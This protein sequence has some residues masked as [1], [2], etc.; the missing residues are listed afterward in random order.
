MNCTDIAVLALRLLAVHLAVSVLITLTQWLPMLRGLEVGSEVSQVENQWWSKSLRITIGLQS[1]LAVVVYASA[2]RLGAWLTNG[3]R[4]ALITD[5]LALGAVAISSAGILILSHLLDFIPE[6]AFPDPRP[7]GEI[8]F[9]EVLMRW[10]APVLLALMGGWALAQ[11]KSIARSLFRTVDSPDSPAS[12]FAQAIL[13]SLL[14]LWFVVG[15]LPSIVQRAVFVARS[16]NPESI[17]FRIQHG[18]WCA[19]ELDRRHLA[20]RLRPRAHCRR[21]RTG[22]HLA[23]R[24]HG[25]PDGGALTR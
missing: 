2:G 25:R 18:L 14:G 23:P 11:P 6:A 9:V 1:I 4:S 7:E 20:L 15:N 8:E 5:R 22:P 17:F 3:D 24:A 21:H 19:R 13:F 10:L 16:T 12:V